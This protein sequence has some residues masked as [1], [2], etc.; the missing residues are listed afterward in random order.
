MWSNEVKNLPSHPPILQEQ[1]EKGVCALQPQHHLLNCWS[2][3][4]V[5]K[6][7]EPKSNNILMSVCQKEKKKKELASWGQQ[8]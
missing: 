5:I 3:F 6:D 1:R 8:F 4:V 2:A 7:D